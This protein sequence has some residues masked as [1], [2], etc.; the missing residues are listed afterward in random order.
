M[1]Q[2]T[3]QSNKT[4]CN[5]HTPQGPCYQHDPMTHIGHTCT[6]TFS[7]KEVYI[8]QSTYDTVMK[9]ISNSNSFDMP[10]ILNLRLNPLL[11]HHNL[12]HYPKF[13]WQ[14]VF[15]A[16][17]KMRS[18]KKDRERSLLEWGKEGYSVICLVWIV[19]ERECT[20]GAQ[21]KHNKLLSVLLIRNRGLSSTTHTSHREG[22]LH[23]CTHAQPYG[24]TQH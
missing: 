12:I 2:S 15:S 13:M 23:F 3:S 8:P 16:C 22:H 18:E 20:R 10:T 5:D 4:M 24:D 7:L 17:F 1:L 6:H 21:R 11:F 14:T 19:P 9:N